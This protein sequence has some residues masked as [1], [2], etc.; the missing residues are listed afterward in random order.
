MVSASMSPADFTT[1]C[2][3]RTSST[4]SRV[5]HPQ[6]RQ[7]SPAASSSTHVASDHARGAGAWTRTRCRN[8]TFG[9]TFSSR[10]PQSLRFQKIIGTPGNDEIYRQR[11]FHDDAG[12]A[13]AARMCSAAASETTRSTTAAA[14]A[15]VERDAR[16]QSASGRPTGSPPISRCKAS[17]EATA[18]RRRRWRSRPD[19]Q[20]PNDCIAN[21]GKPGSRT[22]SAST[23]RTSSAARHDDTLD[24]QR[25]RGMLYVAKAAFFEPRGHECARRRRR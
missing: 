22:A 20:Q 19:G 21:D 2:S 7:T 6:V 16:H 12:R 14:T 3:V 18:D 10:Q 8:A 13:E 5:Q 17:R 25:S 24:R 15:P 1:T 23:S 11:K 9:P 4:A